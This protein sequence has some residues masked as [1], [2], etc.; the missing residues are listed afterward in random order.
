MLQHFQG[1]LMVQS[2]QSTE[3]STLKIQ[4]N[5]EKA[6]VKS[7]HVFLKADFC[8]NMVSGFQEEDWKHIQVQEQKL[9]G[10]R[11]LVK[12]LV[13]IPQQQ[14]IIAVLLV[15]KSVEMYPDATVRK[16]LSYH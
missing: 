12:S 11:C 10:E 13:V 8:R 5:P 14:N 1:S 16:D 9:L 6:S 7:Q 4:F 15:C 2:L 3:L